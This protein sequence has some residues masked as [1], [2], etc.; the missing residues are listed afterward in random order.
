[1]SRQFD[2]VRIHQ[3]NAREKIT[4][5]FILKLMRKA[6]KKN[7][8]GAEAGDVEMKKLMDKIPPELGSVSYTERRPGKSLA[9]GAIHANLI[10]PLDLVRV[11]TESGVRKMMES[12]HRVGWREE[13]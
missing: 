7:A 3:S 1:M 5:D 6:G 13:V 2:W 11:T 4:T 10:V 12:L 9:E 8:Q